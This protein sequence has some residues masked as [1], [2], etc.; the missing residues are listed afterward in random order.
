MLAFGAACMWIPRIS[1][2]IERHGNKNLLIYGMTIVGFCFLYMIIYGVL[3]ALFPETEGKFGETIGTGI[4]DN[5]DNG[6]NPGMSGG[7][8]A[9]GPVWAAAWILTA[10]VIIFLMIMMRMETNIYG[11]VAD[12][13]LWHK[14]PFALVIVLIACELILFFSVLR[15]YDMKLPAK[16]F[17]IF[18]AGMTLIMLYTYYT[19][20]T[21]SG[22]DNGYR[23]HGN[24]YYNSVYN[25]LMGQPYSPD[26]ISVYGHYG[27]ILKG[28][29]KLLGG[30][31]HAFILLMTAIGGLCFLLMFLT[32]HLLVENGWLR[33]LGSIA[34]TFPSLSMRAGFYWQEWPHRIFFM[35]LILFLGAVCI[36]LRKMNI[37]TMAAGFIIGVIA[38]VWNVESGLFV[39]V[40]WA[41]FQ[42]IYYLCRNKPGI[43]SVLFVASQFVLI[44]A[45]FAAAYGIVA[46][47]DLSCGGSVDGVRHFVY[48]LLER[49]YITDLLRVDLTAFPSAYMT[50][51]ILMFLCLAWGI[52]HMRFFHRDEVLALNDNGQAEDSLV[53]MP[54]YA[55]FTAVVSLGQMTYYMNRAA[56]HNL[57]ICHLPSILMICILASYGMEHLKD[58][59]LR[60]MREF[61]AAKLFQSLF[62]LIAC[63]ILVL[64]V[65]G[66]MIQMGYN[67]EL[68]SQF[69]DD[70]ELIRVSEEIRSSV[71]E[72]TYAFGI[73]AAEIYSVLGWD[74]NCYYLDF[75]DMSVHQSV[76][77]VILRDIESKSPE[78][79]MEFEDGLRKLQLFGDGELYD[80]IIGGYVLKQSFE[81]NGAVYN[82]YV[83]A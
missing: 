6:A 10:G 44:G 38:I 40:G 57:D 80:K 19:P 7:K 28:P 71:P 81:L 54:S 20:Y 60:K 8:M 75:P 43:R 52:S 32:L 48:P 61:S 5:F 62:T 68:K 9:S 35:T 64:V 12:R 33:I 76:A 2:F 31:Y 51:L 50:I 3:L 37:L 25:V 45:C 42:C 65:T 23:F 77:D 36:R 34:F 27:I 63:G 78:G 82:Y 66:N 74:T 55:F 16:V 59:D 4:R 53:M 29:M 14:Y 41:G 79:F 83:K 72:N 56:Y 69:K 18:Y 39:T 26:T 17:Y 46:V 70:S 13:Y 21:F 24:A 1:S 30:D 11:G 58:I 73:G 49:D 67:A 47:Y 22:A 15:K